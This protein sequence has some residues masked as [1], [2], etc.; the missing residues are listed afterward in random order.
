MKAFDFTKEYGVVLEGGGAKG[1]YQIGVWK[2]MQ[3]CGI[4]IKAISGVSVGALN[5]TLMCMGDMD[6]AMEL[7]ENITY[8]S[9]MEVD[10][11]QMEHLMK[12]ELNQLDLKKL[13]K[14]GAKVISSFGFDV[15]PLKVLI[16]EVIDHKK[17]QESN[18]DFY[19]STL[20]LSEF[21]ELELCAK[22]VEP[23]KL[24]DYLLASAYFPAFRKEKLGGL[25]YIDGGVINNVPID[26]L[27]KREV[28]DIIVV[29]IY[30]P[31]MEKRIAIPEDVTVIQIA[32]RVAL[33]GVLEFDAAKIKRNISIGY[34]DAMRVF[35]SLQGHIYYL[36]FDLSE[37]ECLSQFITSHDSIKMAY[38]EYY[39]LDYSNRDGY[40]RGLLEVVLPSIAE[41]LKLQKQW[42]YFE[43]YTTMFEV[44][45]K[46]LRI[47][48]YNVYA[49]EE[50]REKIRSR[51]DA[52]KRKRED[53]EMPLFIK[54]AMA[55][56]TI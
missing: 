41:E 53:E 32:P 11:D 10:D 55:F 15:T 46:F 3:E 38:L 9:V 47:R 26:I 2:A 18:I 50:L 7:W 14:S 28:K 42:T 19:F 22:D 29:R 44:C 35:R 30:G 12:L 16:E 54:L 21:K 36:D 45:A 37:E 24:K 52:I 31:G 43:L 49:E 5:G 20:C 51:Y 56:V 6:K 17:I 40:N 25:R 33:G 27:L 4:K 34:F 39:K 13:T 1:A 8:S 23:D 48:K